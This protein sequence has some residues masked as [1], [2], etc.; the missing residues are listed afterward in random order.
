MTR[1]TPR[2]LRSTLRQAA[3]RFRATSYGLAAQVV[4]A[5]KTVP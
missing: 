1:V 3:T 4:L 2:S 5:G